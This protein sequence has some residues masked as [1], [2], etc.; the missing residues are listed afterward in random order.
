MKQ[1]THISNVLDSNY[2]KDRYDTQVKKVLS[3]KTILAWILKHTTS[4]FKDLPI[5]LIKQC[6]EGE[7]EV[8]THRV[9]PSLA[10]E[11]PTSEAITGMDTVD[12]VPGEGDITYDIRFY[13]ITPTQERV[14]LIIN[15]ESQKNYYPGYDLVTR[16]IFYCARM[17][18]AQK[19][20][21][22][23]GSDYDKIK[24][25]YSIWICIN[26]P[27]AAQHTISSYRLGH[28]M[29]YGNFQGNSRYDLM[30]LIMIYLGN[31]RSK[32]KGNSLHEMLDTLLSPD[33][34]P[35][36]KEKILSDDFGIETTTEQ[37]GGLREMCNLSDLIEE[38]GIEKGERLCLLTQIKKK[39]AKGKTPEQIADELEETLE[40][41]QPLYE[42]ALQETI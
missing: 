5:P 28:H 25:V 40:I 35:H 19:E 30:E 34:K 17:I 20:T 15:L 10:P 41:I 32:N 16:G 2:C 6:I 13:V 24:K 3:D 14:K 42:Q 9:F 4:E 39:L 12:K 31:P 36:E 23:T 7:P 37:E 8:G 11:H 38:R 26:A 22:F 18:A 1:K 29:L 21:E 33:L 27:T